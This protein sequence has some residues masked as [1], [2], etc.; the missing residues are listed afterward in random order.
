MIAAFDSAILLFFQENIRCAALTPIMQFFSFI[1]EIGAVCI[2]AG[3]AML[4]FKK[5]RRCGI[6][7]L[8]CLTFAFIINNLVLKN[9]VDRIRPYEIL[10]WLKVIG[11]TPPDSSFPSGHCSAAF[12]SSYAIARYF[13][14]KSP[15]TYIAFGSAVLTAISR[16]YLGVHYPTDVIA[17]IATG[18]IC[19]AIACAVFDRYY[20]EKNS[21]NS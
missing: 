14:K 8:V 9:I 6:A 17:G 11:E 10:D 5:T 18:L 3:L 15:Y 13:G 7:L 4:F 2:I 12:S 16:V 1:F 19:A 21:S 20:R